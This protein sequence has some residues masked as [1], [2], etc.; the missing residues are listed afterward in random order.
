MTAEG[1]RIVDDFAGRRIRILY[2]SGSSTFLWEAPDDVEVTDAY[3]FA[4]KSLHPE[5]EIWHDRPATNE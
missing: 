4:W 3:W 2:D 5:T 1:G